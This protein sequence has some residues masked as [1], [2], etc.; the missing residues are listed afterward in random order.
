M[1]VGH[2]FGPQEVYILSK[3]ISLKIIKGSYSIGNNQI[4]GGLADSVSW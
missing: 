2:D 3:E 1:I 4:C